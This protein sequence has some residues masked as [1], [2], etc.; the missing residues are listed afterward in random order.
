MYECFIGIV[1]SECG[2]VWQYQSF[3]S[4]IYHMAILYKNILDA[5]QPTKEI[6]DPSRFSGRKQQIERGAELLLGSDHAF[7][8]GIR[9]IGKS[10]LARQLALIASG[11][12]DL[13]S[14]IDSPLA[15][16]NF[17]YV[18]C[19]LT[20]D[21]SI[22]N[23]NQ[24]LYRL[25]IDEKA[26]AQWNEL[27]GFDE[28]GTYDLEGQLNAKLVSDFWNRVG[29]VA[30]LSKDGVAIFVDEFELI[31]SHEGFASLIKA[32]QEKCIFIVTGIGKTERE[33]IRDHK[34][35][36]RQIDTGKL[37]VPNMSEDELKSIIS[38]AQEYLSNEIVFDTKA[39]DYLVKIVKGHPYLLHLVG[40]HALTLAFKEKQNIITN[41][42]LNR[43][44]QQIAVTRADRY[45]EDRYL[46]A[47]G[48]SVQRELVLRLFAE[49]EGQNLHT[50]EAYPQAEKLGISNPS[51]WVADLQKESFG[52]ELEKVAEHYYQMRD[53]LFRAY[54]AA[55]PRRL[56]GTVAENEN[57]NKKHDEFV[58]IHVSDIHFG[59]KHYFSSLALAQ[60]NVPAEDRPSLA[61]YLVE[62]LQSLSHP[63]DFLAVTG[64]VTQMALTEEFDDAAVCIKQ[65]AAAL[66][67]GMINHTK[68]ISIIPGNHDVNWG[69]QQAD[70]KARYLGFTP[71]IRF[72]SSLGMRIENQV[73][74]ERLYEIV[75]LID[76][77]NCVIVG[78]NS[79]VLE[80]PEDHR[81]YIGESQFKNAMEEVNTLCRDRKPIKIALMHHH[82]TPV[83]TLEANMKVADEVL[84]DAAFIK[85]SLLENN[86]SMVLHGHRHFAHEEMID[87]NGDGANKLVIVGC[88]STGVTNS[89]RDSQP[90]Q[91]N[92]ISIRELPDRSLLAITVGK[93]FFDPVRRRW[94]QSED[95]KPKTFS[96]PLLK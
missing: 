32:N 21:S 39:I 51:Y 66:K 54:I 79:A 77:F 5:F 75:D 10:S 68:N 76:K 87:Q 95:H 36:E 63:G 8:H 81:G 2:N 24:L 33:L 38:Q 43:A 91:F 40:K 83:N 3:H 34:S 23:I 59:S 50:S 41:E 72:R 86:F 4:S 7:I 61:R 13:L 27:L 15:E 49:S 60:D 46:K 53:P 25:L 30:E 47:I 12:K 6:S 62:G 88:G 71:Y 67:D 56:G 65:I 89:E 28:L 70:P 35:I 48:N 92:R 29:K 52:G 74:P 1:W 37:E 44:L 84:R 19:F 93:Y 69:I 17:D 31:E 9:G 90:L 78:F 45:L 58:I 57:K 80:G 11:K 94:L 73:E 18:T 16:E 96:M 64:D 26:L 14:A 22:S 85:T 82:L 42:T 55:T 20:R